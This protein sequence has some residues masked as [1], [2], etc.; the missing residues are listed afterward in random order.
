MLQLLS[1]HILNFFRCNRLHR[2]HITE[3]YIKVH[4]IP[5]FWI[6][7]CRNI[8]VYQILHIFCDHMDDRITH[9]LAVQSLLPLR[10]D[11]LSLLIHYL[12]IFQQVLTNTKVVILNLLLCLLDCTG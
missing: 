2:D 3:A 11:D 12:V 6:C 9:A 7:I 10:V 5:V 4:Q 8:T 1:I